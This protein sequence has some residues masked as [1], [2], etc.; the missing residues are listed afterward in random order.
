LSGF[1][2]PTVVVHVLGA[3]LWIGGMLFFAIAAPVLRQ[4]GDDRIRA[5][6]FDTL[7]RRFRLVGWVCVAVMLTTGVVQ[8]RLRGWW[9]PAFWS[10][11]SLFGT[12]LGIT[13]VAKLGLVAFM[14]GV[15]AVHDFWLGPQ[16]GS[17]L[18][19]SDQARLLRVRAAGLARLNAFVAIVLVY[20]AVRLARGG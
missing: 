14:I 3:M 17:A 5:D 20:V 8:L 4:V 12:T 16:A 13:L 1:Y 9:G 15:Q 2:L 18:P 6:L 10:R 7:G 19:G 11:S